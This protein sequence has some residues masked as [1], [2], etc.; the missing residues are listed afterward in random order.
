[1]KKF[2]NK[3]CVVRGDR[4]GVFF[5]TVK[6]IDGQTV[7]MENV[8]RLWHWDG[9]NTITEIAT[10]GVTKPEN[11]K[12]TVEVKNLL[13]LDV[14]EINIATEKA[15]ESIDKVQVWTRH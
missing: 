9:A 12:F 14:I 10:N 13:L 6:S 7:E 11:C 1:M 15:I 8:R 5:G 2:I 3:K 4:S